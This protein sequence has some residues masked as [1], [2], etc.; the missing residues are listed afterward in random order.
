MKINLN[1]K[2][3]KSLSN[4]DN[5]EISGDT[6]F[7]YTQNGEII[8]ATYQGGSILQGQ[9]IGKIVEDN[10][11]EFAY[12]HINKDNEIMTGKCIS[13]PKLNADKKIILME[14]WE[15][16]CRDNSKGESTLIE[17]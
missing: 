4:S 1:N 8:S 3:F 10:H 14:Y 7:Y 9:I 15:W 2:Q 13:Y 16:T 17:I 5:G 12:Q 11:L 6:T